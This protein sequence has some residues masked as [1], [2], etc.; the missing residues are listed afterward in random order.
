MLSP[1]SISTVLYIIP[2]SLTCHDEQYSVDDGEEGSLEAAEE[3]HL[4]MGGLQHGHLSHLTHRLIC[5]HPNQPGTH[6][7]NRHE[8]HTNTRG[9]KRKVQ[10][11]TQGR[12]QPPSDFN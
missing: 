8:V 6:T 11:V 1:L 9:H 12:K 3:G 4:G 2:C 5:A 10:R 7:T